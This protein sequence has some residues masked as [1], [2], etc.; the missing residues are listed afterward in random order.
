MN[1]VLQLN[2]QPAWLARLVELVMQL[3]VD[4]KKEL[5][6]QLKKLLQGSGRR[7]EPTGQPSLWKVELREHYDVRS[8]LGRGANPLQ[9]SI[10]IE[11]SLSSKRNSEVEVVEIWK[12]NVKREP[13][14]E[15]MYQGRSLQ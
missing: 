9:Y 7:N 4:V 11:F 13:P 15:R 6:E 3:R 10:T 2:Q 5:P 8:K 1:K 14:S 12:F